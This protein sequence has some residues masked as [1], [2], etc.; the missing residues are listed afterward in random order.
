[1]LLRAQMDVTRHSYRAAGAVPVRITT[2]AV[3][4]HL[5]RLKRT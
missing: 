4:P 3:G 5:E 2:C 1:M